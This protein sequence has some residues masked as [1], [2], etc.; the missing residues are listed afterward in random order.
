MAWILLSLFCLGV[1]QTG[2]SET[3]TDLPATLAEPFILMLNYERVKSKVAAGNM[4]C[5]IWDEQM[6][7]IAKAAQQDCTIVSNAY[8]A[9]G[10]VLMP[11]QD[12]LID[13]PHT[14]ATQNSDFD[15]ASMKCKQSTKEC[16][17][18]MQA[19]YYKGGRVGCVQ[20][21][22]AVNSVI[23][24]F[25]HKVPETE[26]PN[27]KGIPGTSCAAYERVT[28]QK[29]CSQ[30]EKD[31]KRDEPQGTALVPIYRYINAMTGKTILKRSY[32]S[33]R[34]EFYYGIL[35]K[36]ALSQSY[37]SSCSSLVELV[38]WMRGR[39]RIYTTENQKP[40]G[41]WRKGVVLGYVPSAEGICGDSKLVYRYFIW[42]DGYLDFYT[43]D[44]FEVE[45][46]F[47]NYHIASNPFSVWST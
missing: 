10:F 15:F 20:C 45:Y 33:R 39:E 37:T 17:D 36:V 13:Y 3:L 46:N 41:A 22:G 7:K 34:N 29:C 12:R 21:S 23:C 6:V 14:W 31:K 27:S 2:R 9:Y 44:P 42:N 40:R 47:V 30:K 43:T 16:K 4:G 19:M 11:A 24:A 25:E 18:F 8:G 35:G 38:E 26:L 32:S 5:M 1:V 28:D